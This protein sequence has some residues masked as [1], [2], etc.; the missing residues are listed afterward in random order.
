MLTT[1]AA[2]IDADL[3]IARAALERVTARTA[4]NH[5]MLSH[6][7]TTHAHDAIARVRD[8]QRAV[9]AVLAIERSRPAGAE[10]DG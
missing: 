4:G 2:Q 1:D 7:V 9:G 3:A 8:A 6:R 10:V 5:T